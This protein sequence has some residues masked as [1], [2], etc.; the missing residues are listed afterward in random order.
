MKIVDFWPL[1]VVSFFVYIYFIES[2]KSN[3]IDKKIKTALCLVG[4][5]FLIAFISGIKH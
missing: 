3:N 4:I 5:F 1:V 2:N